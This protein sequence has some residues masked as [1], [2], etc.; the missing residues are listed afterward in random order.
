MVLRI[1]AW[2]GRFGATREGRIW[3][4]SKKEELGGLTVVSKVDGCASSI[5]SPSS[6]PQPPRACLPH[7]LYLLGLPRSQLHVF[8]ASSST[9]RGIIARFD[10]LRLELIYHSLCYLDAKRS[11]RVPGSSTFTGEIASSLASEEEGQTQ[12]SASTQWLSHLSANINRVKL[13]Q[14]SRHNKIF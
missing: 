8:Q 11:S 5:S 4:A 14:S 9:S 13:E 6:S 12:P 2:R 10:P 7:G 1:V 3:L